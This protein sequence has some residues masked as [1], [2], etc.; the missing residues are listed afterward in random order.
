MITQEVFEK[1]SNFKE[2]LSN[3]LFLLVLL[4]VIVGLIMAYFQYKELV[5]EN[6]DN[7]SINVKKYAL[8]KSSSTYILSTS[9]LVC[10]YGCA[11]FIGA[12]DIIPAMITIWIASMIIM[13]MFFASQIYIMLRYWLFTNED[14]TIDKALSYARNYDIMKQICIVREQNEKRKEKNEL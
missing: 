10:V 4:I 11:M 3:I 5:K 6:K 9:M 14:I 8:L 13:G 7:T 1:A 2:A 12:V